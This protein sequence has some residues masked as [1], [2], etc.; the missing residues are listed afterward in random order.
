MKITIIVEGQTE[1]AFKRVLVDY[2]RRRLA[3]KMPKLDFSPENGNIPTGDKLKRIVERLLHAKK[4]PS[5]A[6]ITLTDVYTGSNPPKFKDAEDAKKNL[7]DWVGDEA[8]FYPHVA[9]HDFEAW[10]L[11]YWEKI[12]KLTGS[13]S[14]GPKT[15]PEKVNHGKSPAYWLKEVFETGKRSR[16]YSKVLD[17]GR[18]FEGEDLGVAIE[19]CPELKAFVERIIGLCENA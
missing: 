14:K 2:L 1:K 10:L 11:P 15:Q 13:N 7:Q 8:R 12:K 5:D 6:V 19:A 16:S 4:N 3:G 9:L 18:I 17:A